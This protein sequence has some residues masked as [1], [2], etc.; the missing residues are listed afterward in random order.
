MKNLVSYSCVCGLKLV[1]CSSMSLIL[2][3]S[4]S[5]FCFAT[6]SKLFRRILRRRKRRN[7]YV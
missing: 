4:S 2:N 5:K 6:D 7:L 3:S 1:A